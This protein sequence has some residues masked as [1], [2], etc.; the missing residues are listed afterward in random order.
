M[1]KKILLLMVILMLPLV[2]AIDFCTDEVLPNTA[3]Q[4]ITPELACSSNLTIY[5]ENLTYYKNVSMSQIGLTQLYN[6]TFNEDSGSYYIVLCDDSTRQLL[7]RNTLHNKSDTQIAYLGDILN[8]VR[9]NAKNMLNRLITF[10]WTE[11]SP[12]TV[13]DSGGSEINATMIATCVWDDPE[14]PG[15]DKYREIDNIR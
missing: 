2:T 1:N 5:Y 13:T 4:I 12:R 14:T 8:D 7:V 11:Y 10:V 6:Y 9:T 15:C 3:C